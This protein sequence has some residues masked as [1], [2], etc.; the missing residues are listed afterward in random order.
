MAEKFAALQQMLKMTFM[1]SMACPKTLIV[2]L[3]AQIVSDIAN[4]WTKRVQ[5]AEV[6][7]PETE[8]ECSL[9]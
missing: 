6:D 3:R 8:K 9:H 2:H 5:A 7:G 4:K 1:T